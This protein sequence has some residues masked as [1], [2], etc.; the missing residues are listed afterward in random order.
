NPNDPLLQFE[1]AMILIDASRL[2]AAE[3]DLR[4]VVAARP[5]FYDAQRVLGRLLLDR[6]GNDRAKIDE[7][8]SHLQTA[9][10]L[11]PDDIGTG[12][13]VAQILMSTNRINE[14]EAVLKSLLERAP[15]Q[16]ALNYTYAQVL[17]KLGRGDESRQYLERA[18]E[19]DPTFGPA[20]LQLIDI[21]QAAN[22]W[23][24]AA[25]VLQPLINDDPMNLDLR[26]QQ[27]FFYLH[28]GNAEKARA[29]FKSLIEADPKDTRSQFYLAEALNDL[30]QYSE[31]DKIYRDLLEKNPNDA[32]VLASYGLSQAG[33]RKF[34]EASATFNRLLATPDLPDNLQALGKTQLAY[35]A[36]QKGNYQEAIDD[37]KPVLVFRDKPNTQAINIAL[38]AMKRQ[39][40]YSDAI[41]LLQ[42][43]V[44]NFAGDP[45]VNARYVEMLVR[46]GAL[47]RAKMAAATQAKFGAKNTIATAE[48]YIQTEQYPLAIAMLQDAIKKNPDDR[49]L[50]FEL[51]SAYERSG[52]MKSA[53]NA[54]EGIL[55]RSPDDAA[56]LNYLGYMWAEKGLNLDRAADML[57]RAVK[58]EPRNGAYID[59]LGWVY[60]QQGKLDLAEKYLSDAAK[61]LP[62][63]ATVHEHLG[64]VLAKRGDVHRALDLYREALTFEPDSKDEA[65]IRLKIAELE[66][67]QAA[68]H[69]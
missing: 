55:A 31:A 11:H 38:D 67:T 8:L 52:D 44:D 15:D 48:A 62:R 34:N 36:L 22:E 49:D 42:P 68:A 53:E 35:I 24:K 6:A 33:Q 39:K 61:L 51:G 50:K 5:D 32:E 23:D 18:V 59:S 13:G 4:K 7:A 65:K 37:A 40:R 1:R 69:R 46:A 47:D 60:Y 57:N 21:Y 25:E 29:Q 27:A 16:R 56:T 43:L 64:D 9:Y 54:F 28:A 63:D 2:D 20:V 26:R 66:R 14:A 3:A 41:A 19:V 12:M 10:K 45:F 17:T 30:E 58:Q